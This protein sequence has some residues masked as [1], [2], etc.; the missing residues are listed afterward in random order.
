MLAQK[1]DLIGSPNFLFPCERVGSG[2]E[3]TV[4]FEAS[5]MPLGLPQRNLLRSYLNQ[6]KLK[7]NSL[8]NIELTVGTSV[9]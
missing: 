8:L 9:N 3:T 7:A 2:Y 4:P 5:T 6:L 1:F